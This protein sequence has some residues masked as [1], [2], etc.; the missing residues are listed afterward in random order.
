MIS[1]RDAVS[2][3]ITRLRIPIWH[4]PYSHIKIDIMNSSLGPWVHLYEPFN[5]ECNGRDPVSF[6]FTEINLQKHEYVEYFG[7]LPDSDE[8]KAEVARFKGCLTD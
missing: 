4:N 3:G 2:Q 5:E 6:L 8:Y 1:I 7:P